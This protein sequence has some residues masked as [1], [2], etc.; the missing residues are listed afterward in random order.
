MKHIL[1]TIAHLEKEK[2]E[3]LKKVESIEITIQTLKQSLGFS[4][5]ATNG[6]NG[7][8]KG[9][10]EGYD[11]TGSNKSKI[12]FFLKK[13]QRF[14]HITE[15]SALAHA[16]EPKISVDEWQM[17][18]SPA[19]TAL[20]KDGKI[21]NVSG[22]K[23]YRNTFWGVPKWVDNGLII[24]GHEFNQELVREAGSDDFEV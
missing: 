23:G 8:H 17:K 1:D 2:S 7:A 22:G 24:K 4:Q 12:Q 10:Q 18:I 16:F 20:K 15:M 5:N 11:V 13:E 21:I 14:L 9:Q 19:L 3:W 6:V